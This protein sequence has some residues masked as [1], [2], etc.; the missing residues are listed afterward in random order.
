MVPS[1]PGAATSICVHLRTSAVKISCG[2]RE[3]HKRRGLH[4]QHRHCFNQS[5]EFQ[6]QMYAD[7]RKWTRIAD[8]STP[9]PIVKQQDVPT[10]ALLNATSQSMHYSPADDAIRPQRRNVDLRPFAYICG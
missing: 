5:Q 6:P 3:P 9:F 8:V 7:V 1:S 4:F 10:C 2:R